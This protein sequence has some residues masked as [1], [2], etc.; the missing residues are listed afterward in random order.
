MK[1]H[2]QLLA[3][4]SFNFLVDIPDCF[5]KIL[6]CIIFVIATPDV[7]HSIAKAKVHVL[8][9]LYALQSRAMR[10]V[11]SRVVYYVLLDFSSS[12]SLYYIWV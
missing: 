8:S 10:R 2:E 11:V 7:F 3:L 9:D 4:P 12:I 6:D 5:F 1:W